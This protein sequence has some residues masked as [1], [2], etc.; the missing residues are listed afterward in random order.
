MKCTRDVTRLSNVELMSPTERPSESSIIACD[1]RGDD[2][3]TF[4]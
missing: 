2:H 1:D 4:M 3:G